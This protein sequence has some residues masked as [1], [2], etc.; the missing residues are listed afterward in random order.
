MSL[1]YTEGYK[2]FKN[3][4]FKVSPATVAPYKPKVSIKINFGW[5]EIPNTNPLYLDILTNGA[6]CDESGNEIKLAGNIIKK[7]VSAAKFIFWLAL[8]LAIGY[9]IW[10]KIKP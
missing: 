2:K 5:D 6:P 4:I 9:Y 3:Q 7:I 10:T 1:S 8:F